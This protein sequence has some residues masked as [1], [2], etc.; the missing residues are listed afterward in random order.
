VTQVQGEVTIQGISKANLDANEV[1]KAALFE[2]LCAA[3][4]QENCVVDSYEDAS[5]KAAGV[6]IN[7]HVNIVGVLTTSEMNEVQASISDGLT[8]VDD[9]G[10]SVLVTLINE[11]LEEAEIDLEVTAISE[12]ELVVVV[13]D[14][15]SATRTITPSVT[16]SNEST[17]A[18]FSFAA[19]SLSIVCLFIPFALTF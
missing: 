13:D 18:A 5:T 11:A 1:A 17:S 19:F 10:E 4:G 14:P 16:P 7:F 9:E 2:A 12:P 8:E 15:S 3:T 6:L